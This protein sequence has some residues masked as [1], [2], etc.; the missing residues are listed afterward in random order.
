MN[1]ENAIVYI[2]YAPE[3]KTTFEELKLSFGVERGIGINKELYIKTYSRLK[4]HSNSIILISY[5]KS[6]EFYDLRWLTP[7]DPGFLD[8]EGKPYHQSFT[9]VSELAFR[10]GAWKVLW[11]SHLFPF[12]TSQ[13]IDMAFSHIKE[14]SIVIGPAKNKGIYLLGFTRESLKLFDNFYLL[15]EDIKDILIEKCK[16]VKFSYFEMEEKFIVKDDESLK[17]WVESSDYIQKKEKTPLPSA[18]EENKT[19]IKET[20][21]TQIKEEKHKKKH[22]DNLSEQDNK[23]V[24]K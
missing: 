13:D 4:T 11:V 22:K 21:T 10:T 17:L 24:E 3:N 16:K 19:Q 23:I 20:Q 1:R 14:K 7:E 18:A 15:N 5:S 8:T 2:V 12:I 9:L 6:K